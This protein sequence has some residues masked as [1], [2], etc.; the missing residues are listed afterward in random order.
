[1]NINFEMETPSFSTSDDHRRGWWPIRPNTGFYW[2]DMLWLVVIGTIDNH[3][4]PSLTG[5]ILPF[6]LLTPWL[7]LTFV[8]AP[9]PLSVSALLLGSLIQ[10]TNAGCPRGMYLTAYWIIFA[11]I[12]LSRKLLSWRHAVPWIVTF[13][14]S[15]FFIS[16]FESLIILLRQDGAQLDFFYFAK[17]LLRVSFSVIVGMALA[18]PWMLRFKGETTPP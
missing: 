3:V 16:N 5:G 4:F 10:E 6:S 15:S 9:A 13:F 18:Y 2:A 7:V 1:M 11:I 14:I 8:V 12:M 17:Q